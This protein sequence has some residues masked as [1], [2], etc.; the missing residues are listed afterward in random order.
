[1][2]RVARVRTA[3]SAPAARSSSSSLATSRGLVEADVPGPGRGPAGSGPRRPAP[4]ARSSP[5]SP[6]TSH[7]SSKTGVAGRVAV[8]Q[9]ADRVASGRAQ[10]PQ[11]PGDVPRLVEADVA[12]GPGGQG[13][14][15]VVG[16]R[17]RAAPPAAGR[18][19]AAGRGG[20]GRRPGWPGSGPRRSGPWPRAAPPAARRWPVARRGGPSACWSRSSRART[21]LWCSGRAQLLQVARRRPTDRRDWRGRTGLRSSRARIRVVGS[22]RAQLAQ[23]PGDGPRVV[24]AGVADGVAVQQGADRG[25]PA[26][27]S[28]P[29]SP[30]TAHGSSRLAWLTAH[31]A[32]REV[33]TPGLPDT[34]G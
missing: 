10:L 27:R 14:D 6:A 7:G 28:S 15:R 25:G 26:V 20:R 3:L 12:D 21:A 22:G 23:Q 1:M 17:P 31:R 29:S 34:G 13:L 16:L 5:S 11:Q 30:A 8:Q 2:A 32:A 4:A 33:S 24:K 18:C 9:G 19:P